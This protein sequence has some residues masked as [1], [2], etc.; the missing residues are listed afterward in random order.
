MLH[1]VSM[2]LSKHAIEA[3]LQGAS[4]ADVRHLCVLMDMHVQSACVLGEVQA[5]EALLHKLRT[6]QIALP[7]VLRLLERCAF[8]RGDLRAAE[9]WMEGQAITIG[10]IYRLES[11]DSWARMECGQARVLAEQDPWKGTFEYFN[12]QG[13]LLQVPHEVPGTR[14][15]FVEVPG[16]RIRGIEL[17]IGS[18]GIMLRPNP[19][20]RRDVP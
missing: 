17:L 1:R 5:S 6:R 8:E 14:I 9:Q 12:P 2:Q 3:A 15:A 4:L 13:T 18:N 11:F 19:E 10:E 20:H 7:Y 16:L